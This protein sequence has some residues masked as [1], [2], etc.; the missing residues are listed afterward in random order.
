MS[1]PERVDEFIRYLQVKNEY[2]QTIYGHLAQILAQLLDKRPQDAVG[3]I[4]ELSAEIKASVGCPV[5]QD[6]RGEAQKE[7][8]FTD[9]DFCRIEEILHLFEERA[10]AEETSRRPGTARPQAKG[11]GTLV[12]DVVLL[13]RQLQL[14]G[15]GMDEQTAFLLQQRI[16]QFVAANPDAYSLVRFFGR[17]D[18]AKGFYYVLECLPRQLRGQMFRFSGAAVASVN[19][20]IGPETEGDTPGET[21]LA[22]P[23]AE[24]GVP[25][26][27]GASGVSDTPD[28][29]DYAFLTEKKAKKLTDEVRAA[30]DPD[31]LHFDIQT[32]AP[33]PKELFA[34]VEPEG[35]GVHHQG[36]NRF[37]YFVTDD[38]LIDPARGGSGSSWVQ[39]PDLEARQIRLSRFIHI[40]LSGDLRARVHDRLPPFPGVE[41]HYLRC[42]ITRIKHG[43]EVA[44]AACLTAGPEPEES[45]EDE[46]EEVAEGEE[47]PDEE[48]I[49]AQRL[50]ELQAVARRNADFSRDS[51]EPDVPPELAAEGRKARKYRH[52]VL[53]WPERAV[54]VEAVA[55]T[56]LLDLSNWVHACPVLS[57]RGKVLPFELPEEED[58]V[59]QDDEAIQRLIEGADEEEEEAEEEPEGDAQDDPD[60]EE[61]KPTRPT[62]QE[63]LDRMYAE[64]DQKRILTENAE[65]LKTAAKEKRRFTTPRAFW[66][67]TRDPWEPAGRENRGV[68]QRSRFFG[69]ECNPVDINC[70]EQELDPKDQEYW[71][72]EAER[73]DQ[74]KEEDEQ[75]ME[76]DV[77]DEEREV[78]TGDRPDALATLDGDQ[79]LILLARP[80]Y[81]EKL[82]KGKWTQ[83]DFD[84]K[85]GISA[86]SNA[87]DEPDGVTVVPAYTILYNK[88]LNRHS[89]VVV[90]SNRWR[91]MLGYCYNHSSGD[92]LAFGSIYLGDGQPTPTLNS[93]ELYRAP[94]PPPMQL[95]PMDLLEEEEPCL[96]LQREC[97]ERVEDMERKERDWHEARERE[98]QRRLAEIEAEKRRLEEEAAER[99]RARAE[100]NAERAQRRED[101]EE[102]VSEDE[103]DTAPEEGEEGEG[104]EEGEGEGE[105]YTA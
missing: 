42:L 19:C 35:D 31:G 82:A 21:A 30:L 23:A 12:P 69:L 93:F 22:T 51:V 100:R 15:C 13:N 2:G 103:E 9:E 5:S 41:A 7:P 14:V 96:D 17:F 98:E 86:N 72:A 84:R 1:L 40:R 99:R 58:E 45:E 60:A 24:A 27:P 38:L 70:Q 16:S 32:I 3:A 81:S 67:A 52:S 39:L 55:F 56:D 26:A 102:N 33:A 105:D 68:Y 78:A 62:V 74:Y 77:Y 88:T 61:K 28:A 76:G 92:P 25:G 48:K 43:A 29:S 44:P 64:S 4:A 75:A 34:P 94:M 37:V 11:E 90:R 95:P 54:D 46:N 6:G 8:L 97:Q 89:P 18:T 73:E 71:D 59:A 53:P 10:R 36:V 66:Q 104:Q 50:R 20:E 85:L 91:G 49:A 87:A 57:H 83:E 101:G 47:E 65:V 63:R 80:L 79:N